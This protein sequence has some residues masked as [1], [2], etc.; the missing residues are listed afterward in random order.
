MYS[1]DPL[2]NI[3]GS[4]SHLVLGGEVHVWSEQIDDISLDRVVWPRVSAAGEVLWSGA[5]DP[6]SGTNRSQVE[7][8]PRL[9][10]MRERLVARGVAAETMLMP[11]CSMSNGLDCVQPAS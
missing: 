7:A 3:P 2:N 10:E 8:A 6:A 1:L 4:L 9:A 11:F 5:I